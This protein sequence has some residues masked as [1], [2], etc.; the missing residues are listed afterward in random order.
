MK[1]N[2]L[3]LFFLLCSFATFGQNR[4][5]F[6]KEE[7]QADLNYLR[8]SLED[9]QYD[10]YTY[11]TEQA[12]DA[13][14][15][16]IKNALTATE[17]DSL[18]L[19]EATN[20]LQQMAAAVNNGHTS[21]DFPGQSYGNYAYA[22]GTLFPLEIAFEQGK[23]LVRKNWSDNGSIKTGAEV[24]SINGMS[25]DEVLAKIYPQVSA[26]RTYFKN[27]KIELFSFPRY[28]WIVF[29]QQDKYEVEIRDSGTIRTYEL[30]PVSVIEGFEMK[31]SEVFGAPMKLD[32]I[33]DVAYLT[34]G[35]FGGDLE[36]YK[37]FIDSAFV[38]IKEKQCEELIIELRNNTGGNDAFSDYLVSYI[39]D[40]PF[41]WNSRFTLKTSKFLKEH[42][43]A[44]YDTTTAYWKEALT[45][46]DGEVYEYTFDEYQ[47]QPIDKRFQGKVYVLVN[48]QS[49][50]QAAVTAAQIQDYNFGTIVGE[51]TGE[52]P[53]L[54]ASLFQ[55]NLPNTGI[56]VKVSKGYMVRVNGSEKLEG[57]IP[58]IFIKDYLL[59]EN[60]EV[61]DGLLK[62]IGE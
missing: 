6:S 1:A 44:N 24:L 45:R 2:Y 20:F 30:Q 49:H 32:F 3:T 56:L 58:D 62:R 59:D 50:S 31:R 12:F 14:Y 53:S 36:K 23:P 57:V 4:M 42:I 25:M 55:Y 47:P 35:E 18:S 60:D 33:D 41:R 51:E 16:R 39:A 37:A 52:Y 48:R 28:Y 9:A 19:L 61:L 7:V 40:Q 26:E 21:L 15:Q 13:A 11:T 38:V 17:K 43:R 10:I 5:A 22:G 27:A 29:G 46:K 34:P 54:I 8:E